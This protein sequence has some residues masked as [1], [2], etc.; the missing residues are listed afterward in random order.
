MHTFSAYFGSSIPNQR[1][2]G[3]GEGKAQDEKAFF[4]PVYNLYDGP[5]SFQ[6][7]ECEEVP[8]PLLD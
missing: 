7:S 1:Y 3:R 2:P 4:L 5:G 8:D 6:G